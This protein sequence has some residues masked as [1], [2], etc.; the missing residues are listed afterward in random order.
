MQFGSVLV[1]DVTEQNRLFLTARVTN[2]V[3]EFLSFT[4][5]ALYGLYNLLLHLFVSFSS[6]SSFTMFS[7]RSWHTLVKYHYKDELARGFE[8]LVCEKNWGGGFSGLSHL[9]VC[10][11]DEIFSLIRCC[12]RRVPCTGIF[13]CVAY[14]FLVCM[15]P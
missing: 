1:C 5:L 7:F 13:F 15:G 2:S 14:R 9:L 10:Q 4:M 12:Q 8:S 3:R 6:D 11:E